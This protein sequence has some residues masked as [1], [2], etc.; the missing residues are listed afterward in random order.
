MK[1]FLKFSILFLALGLSFATTPALAN[2]GGPT[3]PVGGDR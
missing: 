1:K 2:L 3:S